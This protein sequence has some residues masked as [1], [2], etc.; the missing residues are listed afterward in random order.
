MAP[1]RALLRELFPER[2]LPLVE[3]EVRESG[4]GKLVFRKSL[5][6]IPALYDP[7]ES[8]IAL[9]PDVDREVLARKITRD[10]GLRVEPGEVHL[11][12]LL[13]ELGHA[14]RRRFL[15]GRSRIFARSLCSRIEALEEDQL[16]D[17]FARRVFR[18]YLWSTG[19]GRN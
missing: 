11:W 3:R 2:A 14:R 8:A 15:P 18:K 13:H 17:E 16:A 7:E 9:D 1:L 5:L 19:R 10:A 12:M 6:G 4:V